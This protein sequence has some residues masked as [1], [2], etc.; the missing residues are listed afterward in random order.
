MIIR[1]KNLPSVPVKVAWRCGSGA[2]AVQQPVGQHDGQIA[3]PAL[4]MTPCRFWPGEDP[5]L[6]ARLLSGLVIGCGSRS[7]ARFAC[8]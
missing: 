4:C 7:S 6:F 5:A 1:W 2:A 3:A 8:G